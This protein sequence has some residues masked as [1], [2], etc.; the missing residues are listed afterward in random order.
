MSN[1]V[2]RVLTEQL[3]GRHAETF[4][5]KPGE[6]FFDAQSG[7][8]RIGDGETLGGFGVTESSPLESLFIGPWVYFARPDDSQEVVDVIA[9]NMV[10]ARAEG[11][12]LYNAGDSGDGPWQENGYE[13]NTPYGT[14]WNTEG[15]DDFSNT[16]TRYYEN[17]TNAWS[18]GGWAITKH[19]WIMHD[20][21]NDKYYAIKFLS[22]DGGSNY[23]TGAFSYIRREI[24]TAIYFSRED[25]D[26]EATALENG[27]AIAENLNI[28]RADGGAIFNYG[29]IED[30][31]WTNFT[32]ND[33]PYGAS[34]AQ[35]TGVVSF[36]YDNS[37]LVTALL[38][39]K[40]GDTVFIDDG[41][42]GNSVVVE[43]PFDV[44]TGS[45]T[46]VYKPSTTNSVTYI[47]MNLTKPF[48]KETGYDEDQSPFGTLWN[49]EGYQDLSN[50]MSRQWM[51]F[52]DITNGEYLGKRIV[53]KELVMW[54]TLNDKYYAVT[55]TRWQQGNA[56]SNYPG[57]AYTRR[58]IDV[59]KL[60]A[61]LKFNDGSVQHTA[62]SEKN[63]GTLKQIPR[64]SLTTNTRYITPNDIGKVIYLN[65]STSVQSLKI[66]DGGTVD[67][68]VGATIT[69]I[70]RTG[71]SIYLYKEN[72]D[73]N[74]TIYG[75]GT[76]DNNTAWT[77]P[78]NGGGNICTLMKIETGMD[79][80]FN[81]WMLSGSN[82]TSGD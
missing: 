4:I 26:D 14:Q 18:G 13:L 41:N 37:D 79:N 38:Q 33:Y 63:A 71:N 51:V 47:Y 64:I 27:D 30:T 12:S 44:E 24:N 54:D 7:Q 22:W 16:T 20:T 76:S 58:E 3:G 49:A 35:D 65:S 75:A 29:L 57:F 50:L 17:L 59:N 69:I 9:P 25:T 77:I 32:T 36:E 66:P 28:T 52:H 80:F 68:P 19:N 61:G 60:T 21:L 39:L 34:W 23:A 45:F 6:L 46:T 82:I 70:N 1:V 31:R 15:W 56:G 43:T 42:S 72:D 10:L 48:I 62:Y 67:F 55:F 53:G 5:G 74:G 78:D 2:N 40:A 81:D 8:L 73:E 11:G